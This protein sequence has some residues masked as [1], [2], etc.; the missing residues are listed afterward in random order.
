VF[1]DNSGNQN[2]GFAISDY[3]PKFDVETLSPMKTKLS[4]LIKTATN[5]GAF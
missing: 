4:K 3:N 5:N 2:L 1:S